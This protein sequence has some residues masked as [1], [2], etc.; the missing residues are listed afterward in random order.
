MREKKIETKMEPLIWSQ[1]AEI[2]ISR[3]DTLLWL[4]SL[5]T[6]KKFQNVSRE[7]KQLAYK[8]NKK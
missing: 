6:K 8:N 1:T 2:K 7:K 3:S 5:K 4:E